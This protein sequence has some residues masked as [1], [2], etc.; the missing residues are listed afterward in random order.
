MATRDITLDVTIR[1]KTEDAAKASRALSDVEKE[2]A[3]ASKGMK[4]MSEESKLL[5][6]QLAKSKSRLKELEQALAE[7]GDDKKLR[8][9]IRSERSWIAE[10]EKSAKDLAPALKPVAKGFTDSL[11]EAFKGVDFKGALMPGLIGG[12]AVVAPAVGAMV[13]GA[14][15]GVVGGLGV[16]GG[17]FAASKDPG[18]R[19]AA[20]DLGHHISESFFASGSSFVDPIKQSVGI[21]EK[22]FDA[23]DLGKTFAIAAPYVTE[24]AEGIGGLADE[25]MPG[26]NKALR[27]GKPAIDLF[28]Q[29]LP[30]IGDALGNMLAKMAD[31]EGTLEGVNSLFNTMVSLIE[32]TGTSIAWLGD[33]FH[34]FD[35]AAKNT[36]GWLSNITD[37]LGDSEDTK[38]LRETR[39][40]FSDLSLEAQQGAIHFNTLGGQVAY[41]DAVLGKYGRTTAEVEADQKALNDAIMEGEK[42]IDGYI[43]AALAAS[44]AS[45]AV[46]QDFSDLG[47]ELIRGKK[48]WDVNTQAGRDNLKMINNAIGDLERQREQA[49]ATSDGTVASIDAINRKYNEQMKALEALAVKAGDTKAAFEALAGVYQI[50]IIEDIRMS[51]VNNKLNALERAAK[52]SGR[53]SGGP[54]TAGQPYIVGENQPELFVPSSNGYIM[55]SVPAGGSNH[56]TVVVSAASGAEGAFTSWL[57]KYLRFEVRTNGGGSA[58]VAFS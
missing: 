41:T 11:G 6:A 44:D 47:H 55:P 8:Q 24:F 31:S 32:F 56:T 38:A 2:A 14:V 48:N 29:R 53:A 19:Q 1:A 12:L 25:F 50:T 7:V 39:D 58:D 37:F 54:V 33:R 34:D 26:F 13:A 30:E 22:D 18:V 23:L 36:A 46:A 51:N 35:T 27:D 3:R 9:A 10:L 57:M 42:D 5:D 15:T 40:A 20:S 52:F 43:Q 17:L 4:G 45:I 28:A 49:I 21:L 16:A